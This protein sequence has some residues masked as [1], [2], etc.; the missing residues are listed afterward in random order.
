M[1]S[2][3]AADNT[4]TL[5]YVNQVGGNDSLVFDGGAYVNQGGRMIFEAPRWREGVSTV[6]VDLDRTARQRRENTT[7]RVDREAF[8]RE[9]R[10]ARTIGWTDGPAANLPEFVYPTPANKSFFIPGD[11]PPADPRAA[12][13]E[14]LILAMETGLD[15]YFRKTGAFTRIAIA[16]SGGKDSALTL[17]LVHDYFRRRGVSGVRDLIHCFSLPT[18]FNSE[19]TKTIARS[20]RGARRQFQ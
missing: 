4:V 5:V 12:Y 16:L 3:R 6:D 7:W 8:V 1:I 11:D 19:G 17:L 13:F 15:G 10:E 2:T 18:K 14:D 20:W 9:R